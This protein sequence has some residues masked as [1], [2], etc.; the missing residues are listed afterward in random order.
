MGLFSLSDWGLALNITLI[1]DKGKPYI[2]RI[3]GVSASFNWWHGTP[4]EDLFHC[5]PVI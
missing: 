2:A 1:T 5:I 3:C 4:S